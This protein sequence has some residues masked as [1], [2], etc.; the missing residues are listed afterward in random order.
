MH[1]LSTFESEQE[2]DLDSNTGDDID[3]THYNSI[4]TIENVNP[5]SKHVKLWHLLVVMRRF[6]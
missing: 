5:N 4:F 6:L 2:T 1:F 3:L